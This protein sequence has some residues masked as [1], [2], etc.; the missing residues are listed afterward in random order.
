MSAI[1]TSFWRDRSNLYVLYVIAG[2]AAVPAGL[3]YAILAASGRDH[4]WTTF[5]LLA[6]GLVS[7]LLA[8]QY[9]ERRLVLPTDVKVS[10]N[11][12]VGNV[13]TLQPKNPR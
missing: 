3:I 2:I 8:R 1:R 12:V 13:A 7:A 5:P 6:A 10:A 9:Y 4:W 11:P